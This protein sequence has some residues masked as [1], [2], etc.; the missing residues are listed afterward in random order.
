VARR[1]AQGSLDERL[2]TN[3]RDEIGEL[4][5]SFNEMVERPEG[6]R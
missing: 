5:R 3:R 6:A 1:R 4:N 2:P